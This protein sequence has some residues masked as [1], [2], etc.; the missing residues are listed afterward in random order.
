LVSVVSLL[1]PFSDPDLGLS[2]LVIVRS[3]YE[4]TSGLVKEV[5]NLLGALLVANTHEVLPVI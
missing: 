1:H 2:L 3:I 5:K 4:I